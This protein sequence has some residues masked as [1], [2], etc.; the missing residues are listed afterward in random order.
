MIERNYLN[1]LKFNRPL[2]QFEKV[3]LHEA[4]WR[5]KTSFPPQS[6][7]FWEVLAGSC[8]DGVLE[9]RYSNETFES[10]VVFGCFGI[11]DAGEYGSAPRQKLITDTIMQE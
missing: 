4:T 10:D 11:M 5:R 7:K 1:Y 8:S 3:N 6:P 2:L 9:E